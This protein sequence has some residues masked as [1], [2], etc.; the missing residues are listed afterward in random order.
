[1]NTERL[2]IEQKISIK[3]VITGYDSFKEFLGDGKKR[4]ISIIVTPFMELGYASSPTVSAV[5]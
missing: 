3:N 5:E 1:M 2:Y 4:R